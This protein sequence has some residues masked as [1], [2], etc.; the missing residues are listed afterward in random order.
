MKSFCQI[1]ERKTSN[2]FIV[3][4]PNCEILTIDDITQEHVG[5]HIDSWDK[6]EILETGEA[7]NRICFNLGKRDRY[8]LFIN[9]PVKKIYYL[10]SKKQRIPEVY[11]QNI[12]CRD[13]MR[14]YP[15]Y[16]VIKVRIKP[17]EAYIA[18][19]ENIIHDG[20]TEGNMGV[21]FTCTVRG[22]FWI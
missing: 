12:L 18:P 6:R 21:D 15:N 22:K 9:L 11:N 17:Y 4:K 10:V 19:T 8:F 13:F 1:Y 7:D 20:C 5:M 16:K 14:L 3:S 2:L